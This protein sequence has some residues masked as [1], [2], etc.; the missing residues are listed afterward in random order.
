[1]K[2]IAITIALLLLVGLYACNTPK[3]GSQTETN[4][5]QL[6]FTIIKVQDEKD[7]Q[8]LFLKSATGAVFTTVISFANDNWV[9]G[10]KAGDRISLVAKEI[11]EMHPALII[12]ENI[13][14]LEQASITN[15]QGDVKT[16]LSAKQSI[17]QVGE[18]IV[19]TLQ[20]ENIGE[21][22]YTFLPWGTPI[23]NRFTG[24]CLSVTYQGKPVN[25][26]G[27]MVKRMPPTEA[28]YITLQKGE[29]VS[30]SVNLL[31][32]YKA[33]QPGRYHIQFKERYNGIPASNSIEIEIE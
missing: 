7:G 8:T 10:L 12:S 3:S 25:Y 9:D 31:E 23:E 16:K 17:Y 21:E 30:G 24:D 11:L 20:A 22:P 28:D 29:T 32:G 14:V 13:Q 19:L 1:M 6:Q 27:I 26:V 33:D 4:G 15:T 2:N 5:E 18:P